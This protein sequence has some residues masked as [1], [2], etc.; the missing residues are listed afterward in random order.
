MHQCESA[1]A[2]A[3]LPQALRLSKT[4]DAGD[5]LGSAAAPPFLCAALNQRPEF[6]AFAQ[7]ERADPLRTLQFAPGQQQHVDGIVLQVDGQLAYGL[8]RIR[9]KQRARLSRQPG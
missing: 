2:R 8:H 4:D 3:E 9:M 5:I 6:C 1:P 7:I